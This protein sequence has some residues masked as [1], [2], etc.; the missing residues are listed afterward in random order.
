ME[1]KLFF[2]IIL[3]KSIHILSINRNHT[4]NTNI[5]LCLNIIDMKMKNV[6]TGR[7]RQGN[8]GFV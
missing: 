5:H 6:T 2:I 3:Y 1:L 8:Y 4:I 7:Y